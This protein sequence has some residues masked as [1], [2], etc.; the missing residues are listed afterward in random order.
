MSDTYETIGLERAGEVALLTL[1]RP[2]RLNAI[3]RQ[4]LGELQ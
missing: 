3:N 1:A 2:Q 4:M